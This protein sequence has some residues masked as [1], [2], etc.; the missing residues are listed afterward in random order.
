MNFLDAGVQRQGLQ[1]NK[2]EKSSMLTNKQQTTGH[3]L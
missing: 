1:N 2:N 3:L